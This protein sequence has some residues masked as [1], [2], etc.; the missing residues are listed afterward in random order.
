M[1]ERGE[2]ADLNSI[3]A[4]EGFDVHVVR[5]AATSLGAHSGGA[6]PGGPML[7]SGRRPSE[8]ALVAEPTRQAVGVEAFEQ[9]LCRL[10]GDAE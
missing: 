2:S 5:S 6:A 8:Y 3:Q 10:P 9:E 1:A 7:A 4:L